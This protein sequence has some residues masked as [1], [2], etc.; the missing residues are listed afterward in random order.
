MGDTIDQPKPIAPLTSLDTP[1]ET[2]GLISSLRT[3]AQ[4]AAQDDLTRR[5]DS[6]VA[7]S[8]SKSQGGVGSASI[9]GVTAPIRIA[10]SLHG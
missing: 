3:A 8:P 6:P 2:V 10:V 1:P 7:T 5:S 4:Q 9:S